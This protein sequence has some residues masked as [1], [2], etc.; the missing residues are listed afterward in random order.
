MQV[1]EYCIDM[2]KKLVFMR[3]DSRIR[4]KSAF[5]LSAVM[6]IFI[7][8]SIIVNFNEITLKFGDII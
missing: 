2:F 7:F 3:L 4:P 6:V 1:I 8:V 5:L